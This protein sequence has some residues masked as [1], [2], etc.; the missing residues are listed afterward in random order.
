MYIVISL[1]LLSCFFMQRLVQLA[2]IYHPVS[3]H[4][5]V[6]SIYTQHSWGVVVRRLSSSVTCRPPSSVS[7]PPSSVSRPPSSVVRLSS[8]VLCRPPSCPLRSSPS[9]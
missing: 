7:H 9:P 4:P 2:N 8:S 3:P 6:S 1:P 5:R